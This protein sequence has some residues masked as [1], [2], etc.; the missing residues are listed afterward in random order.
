MIL[1]FLLFCEE[2]VTQEKFA[3]RNNEKEGCMEIEIERIF[4]SMA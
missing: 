3:I 2:N 1:F 4:L